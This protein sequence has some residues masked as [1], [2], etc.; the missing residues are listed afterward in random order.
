[1]SSRHIKSFFTTRID[2]LDRIVIT[3]ATSHWLSSPLKAET[4]WN[5]VARKEGRLHSQSTRKK[6]RQKTL[7]RIMCQRKEGK[8]SSNYIHHSPR[9]NPLESQEHVQVTLRHP[10]TYISTWYSACWWHESNNFHTNPSVSQCIRIC[11]NHHHHKTYTHPPPTNHP[12]CIHK[13]TQRPISPPSLH[14]TIK[15]KI[16]QLKSMTSHQDIA[17]GPNKH[18]IAY[19][20]LVMALK[21]M[22][23]LQDIACEHFKCKSN[24]KIVLQNA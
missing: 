21:S 7:I 15:K 22:K 23:S 14:H 16:R 2:L 24:T 9:V 6:R 5:T 11:T 13:T 12:N 3:F 4:Y 10:Q 18:E 20:T 17:L 8:H 1:M 19:A